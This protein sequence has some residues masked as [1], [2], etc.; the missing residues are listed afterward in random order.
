MN[1]W[2][3]AALTACTPLLGMA[4]LAPSA[5][6]GTTPAAPPPVTP[7]TATTATTANTTGPL[8]TVD[9]VKVWKGEEQAWNQ[10]GDEPVVV[11]L[12]VRTTLGQ[13]GTT[14]T[15]WVSEKPTQLGSG[16]DN[17]D[18]VHVPDSQ[19]DAHFTARKSAIGGGT[20]AVRYLNQ[21]DIVDAVVDQ[22]HLS[23]DVVMTVSFAFDGDF[24]SSQT[25][26]A[27]MNT[28]RE[29]ML[30]KV[31][32]TFEAAKLSA[33]PDQMTK[34]VADMQKAVKKAT[35][36]VW[37]VL[38]NIDSIWNYVWKSAGDYDDLI[39]VSV[40]GFIPVE[41]GVTEN[42]PVD[43]KVAGLDQNW[44]KDHTFRAAVGDGWI[45]VPVRYGLLDAGSQGSHVTKVVQ[46]DLPIEDHVGY[47]LKHWISARQ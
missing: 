13:E 39:G 21:G 45:D 1:R 25:L 28:L 29:M 24:S 6:A 9:D 35:V 38:L 14:R 16:V 37:D 5:T 36:G 43:P 27:F 12:M 23:P 46:S 7:A 33:D 34:T 22:K 19:G 26:M 31:T 20:M 2:S 15:A 18:W 8:I 30:K 42:L 3:R 32:P 11:T 40:L 41:A 17:G 10:N 4:L 44:T 47:D